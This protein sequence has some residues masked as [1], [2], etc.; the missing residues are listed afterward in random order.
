MIDTPLF[1][2]Y[3]T[4]YKTG[5]P[6]LLAYLATFL[7]YC[8]KIAYK[9]ESFNQIAFRGWLENEDKLASLVLP[10]LKGLR[11][12]MS[13]LTRNFSPDNP[14]GKFG[15]RNVSE[16]YVGAIGK[17]TSFSLKPRQVRA[18]LQPNIFTGWKER[19]PA[20][21]TPSKRLDH[22]LKSVK[23]TYS[24]ICFVA[25]D[26]KTSRSIC[27]EP[28][29]DMFFQQ[30]VLRDFLNLFHEDL[31]QFIDLSDQSR[32]QKASL[33]GSLHGELDTL[34][35][36]SASDLLSYDLIKKIMPRH[37]LYW[38]IATR[39]FRVKTKDGALHTLHKFAPMG[40]ALC[41]PVQC[42]VFFGVIV[43]CSTVYN[44]GGEL[45]ECDISERDV[46]ETLRRF[47]P[48]MDR[49]LSQ[50]LHSPMVYGDDLVTDYRISPMVIQ[51]LESLGFKV[52]TSKSY[53]SSCAF[54]ESCG[55][56]YWN[57]YDITPLRYM[58]KPEWGVSD[59]SRY[60]SYVE[61]I[62]SALD[63]GLFQLRSHHIKR[64]RQIMPKF[65]LYFSSYEDETL[66]VKT[67]GFAYNP[68]LRTRNLHTDKYALCRTE[69]RR[70]TSAPKDKNISFAAA[71]D[72]YR[73]ARWWDAATQRDEENDENSFVSQRDL[74]DSRAVWRWTPIRR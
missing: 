60:A 67:L 18:F 19:V 7:L 64:I 69:I 61:H 63:Y 22:G 31:L 17:S 48:V 55:R 51:V 9:D 2:E 72:L 73:Y 44:K 16:R 52:N 45:W 8:K 29:S 65:P 38:L 47:N 28:N 25:K 30:M 6:H 26:L 13:Y 4:W 12:V 56:F 32:N 71:F 41:F 42:L 27:I 39:S 54:R 37:V 24:R 33:Y 46:V 14:Y 21:G 34:D 68:H 15:P 59:I 57:G 43:Y 5:N 50:N 58:I 1:R 70:V 53:F 23:S 10:D 62:N 20:L 11:T 66:A 35:L 49:T 3:H 40:S 36:S 74:R